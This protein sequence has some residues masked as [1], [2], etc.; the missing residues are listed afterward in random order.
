MVPPRAQSVPDIS[1]VHE[2]TREGRIVDLEESR[3]E[4][5]AEIGDPPDPTGPAETRDGSG[6]KG[7]LSRILVSLQ[8]LEGKVDELAAKPSTPPPRPKSAVVQTVAWW[9]VALLLAA[10]QVPAMY[11]TIRGA[12]ASQPA[13]ALPRSTP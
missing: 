6:I 9:I 2:C 4:L 11:Q 10:Q 12:S 7:T 8:R 5:R 3:D 1:P 13:P